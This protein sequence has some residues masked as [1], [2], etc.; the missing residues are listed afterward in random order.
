MHFRIRHGV[1]A[2]KE[3]LYSLY[4]STMRTYIEQTWG[5][6]EEFQKNGFQSNLHPIRFR[7]VIVSDDVV[8]AYLINEEDDHYL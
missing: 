7:I 5:W 2:D 8:G 1:I 3:W 4:C 6:D